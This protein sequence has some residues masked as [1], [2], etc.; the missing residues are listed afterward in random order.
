MTEFLLIIAFV[1]GGFTVWFGVRVMLLRRTRRPAVTRRE[2]VVID[3]DFIA[4]HEPHEIVEP[5]QWLVETCE[6]PEEY[7]RSVSRFSREQ[8]LVFAQDQYLSE[9][10]SG[11]H[12]SFFRY[13]GGALWRD[14]VAGLEET[15]Q[16]DLAELLAEAASRF[17]EAVPTDVDE[18]AAVLDELEIDFSDLDERLY[19]TLSRSHGEALERYVAANAEAFLLDEMVER[20][21][22][23]TP[24]T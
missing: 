8:R 2:R 4:S 21:S 12:D 15:G 11:G 17:G 1:A 13:G 6:G 23:G 14:A 9:V 5:M 24:S 10:H 20:P 22:L 16:A 7:E 19:A 18:R 3:A